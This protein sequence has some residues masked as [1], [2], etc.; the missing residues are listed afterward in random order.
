MDG[1]TAGLSQSILSRTYLLPG[2]MRNPNSQSFLKAL[3]CVLLSLVTAP[4]TVM[5]QNCDII[6]NTR[7]ESA[8][9]VRGGRVDSEHFYSLLIERRMDGAWRTDSMAYSLFLNAASRAPVSDSIVAN[10][11]VIELKLSNGQAMILENAE[12]AN[13]PLG[14]SV[15]SVGF[16]VRLSERQMRAIAEHPVQSLTAFGILRTTF[17]QRKMKRQQQITQCL[18]TQ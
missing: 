11:G 18:L 1:T 15:P 4:F 14:P 16:N 3:G 5:G 9:D 12:C 6:S 2:M 17:S 8:G 7:V 13:L 10:R